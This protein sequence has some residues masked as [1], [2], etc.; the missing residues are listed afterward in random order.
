M[1][2]LVE[3]VFYGAVENG[4]DQINHVNFV[5]RA[6][7]PKDFKP[8]PGQPAKIDPESEAARE[9]LKFLKENKTVVEPTLARSELNLN[10]RGKSFAEKEPGLLKAPF[11]FSS[12]IDSMGVSPE[13]EARAKSSFELSLKI[14]KALHTSGI[15]LLTGTDLAVPGHSQYREMELFVRA[16]ISPLDAIKA[17]TIVPARVFKRDNDLGTI[18]KGKLA[19]LILI[20]GD[21]LENIGA[22]RKIK[23]V[24]R[25]GSMY[26]TALIW[27]SVGFKP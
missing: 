14:T 12:L 18:E 22:M 27:R 24:V 3:T 11:E 26:E 6:M 9:G 17:A 13:I 10:V 25:D 4:F 16:G 5:A 23:F 20:D 1:I 7:L 21:P 19:D 2:D 15:P 8:T